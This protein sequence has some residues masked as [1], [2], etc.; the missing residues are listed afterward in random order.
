M[1]ESKPKQEFKYFQVE[2]ARYKT[3]LTKK[4]ENRKPY[5]PIDKK[6]I[7]AFISGTIIKIITK[8]NKKVN[9]GDK[10]LILDAMKMYNEI[11]SPA[12]GVI[13]KIHVETG[14]SVSKNQLL[15]EFE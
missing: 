5:K 2:F 1:E 12:K 13:K 6:K 8:E 15:I 7:K 11:L 14:Q 9:T 3:L 4:F 10:L